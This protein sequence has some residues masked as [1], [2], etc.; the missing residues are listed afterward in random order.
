M[1]KNKTDSNYRILNEIEFIQLR[2]RLFFENLSPNALLFVILNSCFEYKKELK[3]KIEVKINKD[4]SVKIFIKSTN[5]IDKM[6]AESEK[7]YNKKF[8]IDI[9]TCLLGVNVNRS[10]RMSLKNLIE[11]WYMINAFSK[12]FNLDYRSD[13]YQKSISFKN[14]KLT[15]HKD[16]SKL[17]K[18]GLC[19]TFD[20]DFEM[21]REKTSKK[22]TFSINEIKEKISELNQNDDLLFVLK[23]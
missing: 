22:Q 18:N 2:H 19:L 23:D 12:S 20:L 14:Q 21:L 5:I 8:S 16:K 15:K 4:N 11:D 3:N 9:S 13:N 7:E 6:I 10:Y 17:R 1:Q